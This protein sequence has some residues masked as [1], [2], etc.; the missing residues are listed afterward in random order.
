[1]LSG[2]A[3]LWL[4]VAWVV[5]AALTTVTFVY[6]PWLG[7]VIT[8]VPNLIFLGAGTILLLR[9]DQDRIG[10]LMVVIGVGYMGWLAASEIAVESGSEWA[11]LVTNFAFLVVA[12]DV[13]L[14]LIFPT[15]SFPSPIWKA[16][17]WIAGL[18]GVIAVVI[19]SS[20]TRGIIAFD[21]TTKTIIATFALLIF[22][23]FVL[24]AVEF[25]RRDPVERRQVAWF[26]LALLVSAGTY[27]VAIV[28]GV[29][30]EDFL[31]MD[32]LATS[33]V[34]IA[35]LIAITRYR[36]YEIDRIFSRTLT[37][38]VVVVALGAVFAIIT[39]LPG[40]LIGGLNDD[41]VTTAPPVIIALS[42]LVVAALFNPLRKGVQLRVDRRFNRTRYET[43]R[44]M[45]DF[46]ADIR[47]STGADT[48]FGDFERIVTETMSP[49]LI[50]SWER[51]DS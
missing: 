9:T 33:L 26:L 7:D 5:F 18:T 38:A 41:G 48:V 34:P 1:M 23:V 39:W 29:G 47:D 3:R 19:L 51:S 8:T 11:A 27:V 20:I 10:W 36:L 15:G 37:Y 31:L 44:V 17:G 43:Q 46:A 6:D 30:V 21:Q 13:I 45:D 12:A 32:A 40:F 16:I 25:R 22:L 28:M 14:L 35:V 2:V 42:T 24:H 49:S 50:G 4:M